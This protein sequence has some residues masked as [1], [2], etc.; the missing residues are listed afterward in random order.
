M[1]KYDIVVAGD[2]NIDL[3]FNDFPKLPD[4]GEEVL[5]SQFS[6]NLG[7]SAGITA[8]H[9]AT[10]G[11]KVA[12]IGAVGND[13]FGHQMISF[14]QSSGICTDYM[15]VLDNVQTG[16]TVVM[17]K[18]EDRANLTHAGAMASLSM[19]DIPMDLVKNTPFFH[20][21]NPYVLPHFR[22]K[23]PEVFANIK[24][25]NTTTSLDP[26][27]DVE[28]KWNTDLKTLLPHVDTFFPNQKELRLLAK[29]N[30]LTIEELI[31]T[32]KNNIL[33]TCGN[34]GVE[35][36]KGNNKIK[37]FKGYL[38]Q[39]AIDCI[40]AGDAFTAGYLMAKIENRSDEEAIDLG[41]KSGALSTTV[42]GGNVSYSSRTDFDNKLKAHFL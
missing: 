27:W 42:E 18:N 10:L 14:L 33:T 28:E 35:L 15:P 20:M 39:H 1:K 8:V 30:K 11:A 34:K 21:S 16:C 41:C 22:N 31:A 5:A 17:S 37:S 23:L 2:C 24:G 12:F 9:L 13:V 36:I 6:V 29:G 7:S 25:L 3:I 19:D 4:F 40:G 26:Q 38:N 32:N